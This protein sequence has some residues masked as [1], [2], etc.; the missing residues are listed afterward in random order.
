[1]PEVEVVNGVA[2]YGSSATYSREELMR[3]GLLRGGPVLRRP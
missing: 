1:V 2:H 3:A